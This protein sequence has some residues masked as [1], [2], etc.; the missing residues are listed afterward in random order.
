MWQLTYVLGYSTDDL[1]AAI[2]ADIFPAHTLERNAPVVVMR[3]DNRVIRR[4]EFE[5]YHEV[6]P[7][8]L[9]KPFDPQAEFP[10]HIGPSALKES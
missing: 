5:L 10:C 8:R 4:I 1:R 7:Q 9:V 6:Q 3:L 2:K